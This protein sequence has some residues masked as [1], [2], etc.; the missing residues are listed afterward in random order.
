[1]AAWGLTSVSAVGALSA[2]GPHA[3]LDGLDGPVD[4]R[5]EVAFAEDV[6]RAAATQRIAHRAPG[7]GDEQPNAARVEG[8]VSCTD[9][10]ACAPVTS[11]WL[12][13]RKSRT[14]PS[15]RRAPPRIRVTACAS[16][17]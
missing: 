2:G 10:S 1:M 9:R 6:D 4:A 13:E 15:R 16:A 17:A 7:V 3:R 12:T 14:T 11:T 5:H 8:V